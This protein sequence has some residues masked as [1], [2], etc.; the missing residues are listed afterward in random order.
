VMR[1]AAVAAAG[2]W[3]AGAGAVLEISPLT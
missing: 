3:L 1:P 2:R